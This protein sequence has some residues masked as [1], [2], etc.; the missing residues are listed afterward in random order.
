M[1]IAAN[2]GPLILFDG[3]CNLCNTAVQ[4]VIARDQHATFRFASLQ[5]AAART[6]IEERIGA[7][8]ASRLPDSI[9]LL[10]ERGLHTRSTAALRIATKL[11]FPWSLAAIWFV[12]PRFLRDPVYDFIGKRRYRWFGKKDACMVPSPELRARFLDANEPP[13]AP[14]GS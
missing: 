11:G 7:D 8:A 13:T 1:P 2:T 10:D 14:R 4:W 9:V 5:S 12:L 6:A 3:V